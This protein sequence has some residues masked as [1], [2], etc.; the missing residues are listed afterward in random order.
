MVSEFAMSYSCL[1]VT[2]GRQ[3]NLNGETEAA[4]M[5]I[6]S[7]IDEISAEMLKYDGQALT[8]IS[9]INQNYTRLI[10]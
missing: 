7:G 6:R 4:V 10:S 1:R 5:A 8:G 3:T 2:C 9:R